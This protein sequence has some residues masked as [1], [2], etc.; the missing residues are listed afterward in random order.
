MAAQYEYRSAMRGKGFLR[1][2]ELGRLKRGACAR[3][4]CSLPD[5][6]PDGR[7]GATAR[8]L[9]LFLALAFFGATCRRCAPAAGCRF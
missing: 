4:A 8:R 6:S 3:P 7:E 1:P 5:A 2:Q 9:A